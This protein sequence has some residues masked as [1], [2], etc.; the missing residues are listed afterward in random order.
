MAK[1]NCNIPHGIGQQFFQKQ[2]FHYN[3]CDKNKLNLHK[4][5]G[6]EHFS[7]ARTGQTGIIVYYACY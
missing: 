6:P 3:L 2:Q 7:S 5:I 1:E 4:H